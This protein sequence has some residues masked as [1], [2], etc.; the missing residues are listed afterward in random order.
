M[1]IILGDNGELLKQWNEFAEMAAS[2][3]S[4]KQSKILQLAAQSAVFCGLLIIDEDSIFTSRLHRTNE[5]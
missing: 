5:N 1:K 2:S 4:G 3:D